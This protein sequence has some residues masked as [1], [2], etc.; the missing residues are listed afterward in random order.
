METGSWWRNVNSWWPE[1][2][3]ENL[4]WLRYEDLVEDLPEAIDRIVDHLGWDVD[5]DARAHAAQL[6]SFAWMRANQKRF[7][8]YTA[9]EKPSFRPEGFIRKGVVGDHKRV[10][11][12]THERR[13]LERCRAECDPELLAFVGL[14]DAVA[15]L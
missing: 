14:T 7:V 2:E 10:L 9:G 13:I 12:E 15:A 8:T 6:S 11:T 1:R 3:R 5:L 4:L